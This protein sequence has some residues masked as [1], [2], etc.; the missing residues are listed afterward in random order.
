MG[1]MMKFESI[2]FRNSVRELIFLIRKNRWMGYF[3]G[4]ETKGG[5]IIEQ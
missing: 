4:W 2:H 5:F 1:L 3:A